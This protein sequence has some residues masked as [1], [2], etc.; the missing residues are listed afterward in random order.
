VEAAEPGTDIRAVADCE[1]QTTAAASVDL[2][3]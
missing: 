2:W 3:I 1:W